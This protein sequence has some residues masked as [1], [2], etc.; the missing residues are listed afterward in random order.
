M[1]TSLDIGLAALTKTKQQKFK[2]GKRYSFHVRV[3]TG[4]DPVAGSSAPPPHPLTQAPLFWCSAFSQ[5]VVP[6]CVAE[7]RGIQEEEMEG[8]H[9]PFK[10]VI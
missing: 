9:L 10:G 7:A 6:I 1:K 4:S 3:P 2:Q 5:Y 8:R